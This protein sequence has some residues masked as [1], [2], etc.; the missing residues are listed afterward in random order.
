MKIT[1]YPQS[2]LLLEKD[3]KRLL[4]DPGQFVAET[5]SAEQLGAVDAVL[6]THEHQDHA[7]PELIAAVVGASGIPVVGN[8][9]TKNALGEVVTQVVQDGETFEVPGFAVRAHELPHMLMPDGSAGPQNTGYI[10]DG[11]FFHPGDGLEVSGVSVET[12]GVAVAGPDAS[13]KDVVGF[14]GSVHAKTVIP[15]HF[16][17]HFFPRDP[18]YVANLFG[19]VLPDVKVVLL[20]DG[21]SAEV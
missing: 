5:F 10:I 21:E 8:H 16:H 18:T 17:H 11:T 7:D 14:V 1:K 12:T 2:C 20:Q 19:A 3:G 9:G 13:P 4:I 6:I 15:L